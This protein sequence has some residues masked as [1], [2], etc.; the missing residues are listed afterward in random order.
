M[1]TSGIRTP[2][3]PKAGTAAAAA[4][5]VALLLAV[6]GATNAAPVDTPALPGWVAGGQIA[7]GVERMHLRDDSRTMDP[8]KPRKAPRELTVIRIDPAVASLR[9]ESTTGKAGTAETVRDQLITQE[10]KPFAAINGSYFMLEGRTQDRNLE[11]AQSF[12]A[13]VRDGELM[14]AACIDTAKRSSLILQYGVP[15]IANVSTVMTVAQKGTPG[16]SFT[17]DDVNRVPGTP[18]ACQRE[19]EDGVLKDGVRKAVKY[20]D[21][22]GKPVAVWPDATEFVLFNDSYGIPTPPKGTNTNDSDD[23]D[24]AVTG[25]NVVTADDQDGYEVEVDATGKITNK[26]DVRGNRTVRKGY[27]NLQAIGTAEVTW[28]KS[29]AAAGATLDIAQTLKDVD[30]DQAIPLDESVDVI[31]G[32]AILMKDGVDKKAPDGCSRLDPA[33]P[34]EG[35]TQICRSSRTAVGVDQQGRTLLLTVT[36][37]LAPSD[38]ADKVDGA[39]FTEVTQAL[40]SLGAMDAINLDGGGSTTLLT[41]PI[42]EDTLIRESGVSDSTGERAVFDTVYGGPGG[43]ALPPKTP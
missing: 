3:L 43:Y 5:T 34:T 17:L 13:T 32:G 35:V 1:K 28:L 8:K 37:P 29:M 7:P 21:V 12:G 6:P 42:A 33:T 18:M 39:F 25:T 10:R 11:S 22:H 23:P 26:W 41:R 15:R 24:S 38:P 4:L 19:A 9:I 2:R 20:T 16:T 30:L 27:R 31:A 14:G 40:Q 36:G